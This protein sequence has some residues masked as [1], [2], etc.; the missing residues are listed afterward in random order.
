[1][2]GVSVDYLLET[3]EDNEQG[4]CEDADV[5]VVGPKSTPA[6][7]GSGMTMEKAT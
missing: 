5:A 6:V 3:F 4:D 2:L 1:V 7:R